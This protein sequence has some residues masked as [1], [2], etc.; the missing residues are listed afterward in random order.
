MGDSLTGNDHSEAP[1]GGRRAAIDDLTE[2]VGRSG[3]G[4]L[5]GLLVADFARVLAGPYATMM[6]AD[7]GATVVKVESPGGDDTRNWRPPVRGEEST[8]FLSANRNKSSIVLDLKDPD[9]VAVARELARR[10]DVLVENFK[11]GGL[12]K[13]GL[14]WDSV[15]ASNSSLIYASVTGFGAA[16][17]QPGY[18][19]LVQ[20]LSGLMSLTGDADGS[21][22]RAGVAIFDVLTGLHA[23]VGVLAALREREATGRG[24]HV[25]ANLLSSA[26]SGLVNQ[27]SAYVAGGV[28]P[29]RMGNEHPSLYPY[30]PL[31]TGDG[32]LILT[33]G[34][35]TQFAALADVLGYP[36]WSADPRFA[37]NQARNAHRLELGPLLVEALSRRSSQEWH[38][39]LTPRNVPCAPINTVAQGVEYAQAIGLNPVV[40]AR[41]NADAVP[42]VAN[43]ITLS[44]SG[45]SYDL[46]PPTL[47]QHSQVVRQWLEKS[48]DDDLE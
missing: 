44:A 41:G 20:G 38:D 26:L 9:D 28:T 46:D 14:D 39:L 21:P 27:T 15:H 45:V 32:D 35:D 37:V 33:V 8:Y 7:L 29:M 13:Y 22:M 43:P 19:L 10:A 5:A 12:K 40:R 36:E 48:W 1:R 4:P 23:T 34:N 30:L 2:A 31:P 17:P 42:T 6:L 25:E 16:N 3:T 11:P 24:Q 18:D 47:G